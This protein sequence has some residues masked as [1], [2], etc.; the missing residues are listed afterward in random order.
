MMTLLT[1]QR[2]FSSSFHRAV[3]FVLINVFGH[4]HYIQDN[5]YKIQYLKKCS[6]GNSRQLKPSDLKLLLLVF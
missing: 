4:D 5:L 1:V 6:E 3:F 2:N